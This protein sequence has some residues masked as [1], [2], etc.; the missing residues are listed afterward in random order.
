M[1][2]RITGEVS[3]MCRHLDKDW[4]VGMVLLWLS[5]VLTS[6]YKHQS[7]SKLHLSSVQLTCHF[8]KHRSVLLRT[9]RFDKQC[10]SFL[11]IFV[12]VKAD[13]TSYVFSGQ[14]CCL[15][16]CWSLGKLEACWFLPLMPRNR[17]LIRNV[18]IVCF[19]PPGGI[20][21]P[22]ILQVTCTPLSKETTKLFRSSNIRGVS[23]YTEERMRVMGFMK[24]KTVQ[25][26]GHPATHCN[27]ISTKWF[28]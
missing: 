14:L 7:R 6:R 1:I 10:S 24:T 8:N 9:L 12:S 25:H 22:L 19:L 27:Q 5:V 26:V 20:G 3:Y 4:G 21:F 28:S 2:V 17:S 11:S 15:R 18:E 23:R 13:S 16:M